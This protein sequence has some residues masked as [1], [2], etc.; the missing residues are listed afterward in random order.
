MSSLDF[1]PNNILHG[2]TGLDGLG[3]DEVLAIIGQP[4][5]NPV[6]TDE[7]KPHEQA[8]APRYLV[9][10]LDWF[11]VDRKILTPEPRI[12]DFGESFYAT[13]PPEDLGTP[14]PY[15]SPELMLDNK[16]GPSS[17]V[18]ALGCTLFEIRTGRKLFRPFGDDD[19]DYLESM[20]EILGKLPEPWWSTTWE[21]RRRLF[22][23]EVD[24]NG[25]VVDAN[26]PSEVASE[27]PEIVS[28]HPSVPVGARSLLDALRPGLWHMSAHRPGSFHQEIPEAEKAALADLLGLLL[29]FDPAKRAS[30][31]DALEHEW[32]RS[33]F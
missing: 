6:L 4:E 2:V 29:D 5:Q 9:Y 11:S 1:T 21:I 32:F 10:P 16:C 28:V 12:I 17:D 23:D 25:H 22:K 31:E 24:A 13:N 18:W 19:D 14:G 7:D 15:R 26:P 20:C 3:E 30:V 33:N 8:N 27:R